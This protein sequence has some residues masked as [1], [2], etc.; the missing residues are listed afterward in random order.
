[1]VTDAAFDALGIEIDADPDADEVPGPAPNA[2]QID[3]VAASDPPIATAS[4]DSGPS[5]AARRTREN[6]KQAKLS[7]MGQAGLDWHFIAPEQFGT[8]CVPQSYGKPMQNGNCEAFNGRMRDE[9]LNETLFFDLDQVR[10][11]IAQWVADYNHQRPHSALGYATPAAFAAS[12]TATGDRLRNPDP[13]RR[14][15]VAPPALPRHHD[16]RTPARAG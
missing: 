12:L 9:L 4:G 7:F 1:V 13:L 15:P 14:S 3:A 11:A 16:R 6:T 10:T 5:G 2:V 8:D